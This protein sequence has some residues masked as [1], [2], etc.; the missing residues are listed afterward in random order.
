MTSETNVLKNTINAVDP[1]I[2]RIFLPW[3]LK[4]PRYLRSFLKLKKTYINSKKIRLNLKEED[5]V[6]PPFFIISITS[7][8]NLGCIGCYA[9]A[10]GGITCHLSQVGDSSAKS[11]G[12][13]Q[14]HSIIHQACNLGVF[15]FV[16]AGG[17]PFLY[18]GLLDFCKE[19]KDR[20][21]I[22]I[23]NNWFYLKFFTVD[24]IQRYYHF[25]TF[26]CTSF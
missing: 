22:I 12:W 11:L 25:Q 3:A 5:V 8:C 6:I 4:N 18:D 13:D 23:T 1:N 17:E 20:F 26:S 9:S 21:F 16:F 10:V 24:F 2:A 19:F 15:G 7:K 14:W